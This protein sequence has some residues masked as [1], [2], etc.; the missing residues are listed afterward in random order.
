MFFSCDLFEILS[1]CFILVKF[2]FVII[3]IFL[4]S[5][6]LRTYVLK[7]GSR[8]FETVCLLKCF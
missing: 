5:T 6:L 8:D 1:V 7:L 2:C 3:P 4:A